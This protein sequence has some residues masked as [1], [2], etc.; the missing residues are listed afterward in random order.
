MWA[1]RTGT[2]SGG[3]RSSTGLAALLQVRLPLVVRDANDP[4]LNLRFAAGGKMLSKFT[5]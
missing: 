4:G 3:T 2:G 1:T 5:K